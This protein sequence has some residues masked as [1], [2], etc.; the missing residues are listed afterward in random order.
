MI[1]LHG[2]PILFGWQE[3]FGSLLNTVG[4]VAIYFAIVWILP[5]S[6]QI[7]EKYSPAFG[8]IQK[9]RFGILQ[10]NPSVRWPC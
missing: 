9:N 7:L 5:N 1:G 4:Q 2:A 10:W 3:R 6:Q 8:Q